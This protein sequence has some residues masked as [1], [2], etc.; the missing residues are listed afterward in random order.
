MAAS[1]TPTSPATSPKAFRDQWRQSLACD[2]G[3]FKELRLQVLEDSNIELGAHR[4]HKEQHDENHSITT[5][6][7]AQS[8]QLDDQVGSGSGDG[9]ADGGA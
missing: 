9:I 5:S 6:Q 7:L 4:Y 2:V 3:L 8:F 1:G